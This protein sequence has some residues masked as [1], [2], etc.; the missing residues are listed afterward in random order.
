MKKIINHLSLVVSVLFMLLVNGCET[1]DLD[2]IQNP[3][4]LLEE[5]ASVDGF[6]NSIQVDFGRLIASLEVEASEAVRILNMDGLNYQNAFEP[7]RFDNE[8]EEAYQKI[9]KDIRTMMPLAEEAGQF[10]HIGMAQVIEAYIMLTLVDFFGDVPYSEAFQSANNFNPGVAD[11]GGLSIYQ[12][13]IGLLD[14]AIINFSRTDVSLQ[15]TNDLFYGG[16]S[17]DSWIK[18]A[19]SIKL[20]I[21]VATRNVESFNSVTG[22]NAIINEPG[23]YIID[24]SE[25]F[26]FQWG[27]SFINP[28]TRHPNYVSDYTPSGANTYMSNWYMDYM[29]SHKVGNGNASFEGP[30]PRMKY[31]FYRQE[32]V[33]S[34]SPSIVDCSGSARPGHYRITDPYCSL[35]NGYWGRDH[36]DN[37]GIPPDS[38][39]R[40][41]FG[42]YPAGGKFDDDSF[43]VIASI[44]EGAAGAGITP[45][46]T[47]SWVD[48]MRAEMALIA[49]DLPNAR[50]FLESGIAKSFAKVRTFGVLDASADLS[51]APSVDF[52]AAYVREVGQLFD[53]AAT[54]GD[55]MDLLGAE[56][57]V[58]LWGNG[59]D[60]FNFYRRTGRPSTL[61]PN[62]APQPGSFFRTFLYPTFFSTRNSSAPTRQGVAVDQVFW[63]TGTTLL[64]N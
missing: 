12:S 42:V 35:E 22:F 25:D 29:Q 32:A 5:E 47:A 36:G 52:D 16:E 44:S 34:T 55:R 6:I 54:D 59:I 45:I 3:N 9:L 33:V 17:W 61:Q 10:Y 8:W 53:A 41:T 51:T 2:L 14:N 64:A 57:F 28:D 11:D 60:A 40:T 48:M 50:A 62:R 37:A 58:T 4:L 49:N 21:Y 56:Y 18:A 63:D 38:Q 13:A 20:K 7:E 31:Y 39:R 26:Q 1:T 15:P 30:D 27:T 46:M 24:N 19:N 43:N 23:S